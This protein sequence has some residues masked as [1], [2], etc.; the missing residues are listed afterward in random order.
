MLGLFPKSWVFRVPNE[1][2]WLMER[3][4]LGSVFPTGRYNEGKVLEGKCSV[5]G[6]GPPGL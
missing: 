4:C 2:I 5:D 6:R 1:V 3:K